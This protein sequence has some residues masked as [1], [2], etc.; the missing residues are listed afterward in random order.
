M[1]KENQ[2]D[3]IWELP[4]SSKCLGEN[5]PHPKF[6]PQGPTK[7]QSNHF[8]G[9]ISLGGGFALPAALPP[10]IRTVGEVTAL[11]ALGNF[12]LLAVDADPRVRYERAFAR[13]QTLGCGYFLSSVPTWVPF[14]C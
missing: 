13:D 8:A 7:G 2:L 4:Q 5:A 6:T 12:H 11:R 9:C 10:S 3:F 1:R 14:W